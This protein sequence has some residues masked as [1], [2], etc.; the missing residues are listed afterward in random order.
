MEG[1]PARSV[2]RPTSRMHLIVG[3]GNPG[4]RYRH[5][6]HN[7]GFLTVDRLASDEKIRLTRKVAGSLVGLGEIAGTDVVLAKPLSYMNL[8]GEPVGSLLDCCKV[9][10]DRLLVVYDDLALPWTA[11]RIR[12]KGS[13]GGHRGVK[14]I[15]ETI[16]T[17]EFLRLRLGIRPQEPVDDGAAYVLAP[18]G[19]S[20]R[21][22]LDELLE[23]AASAVRL[24]ISDGAA[25]AM[26]ACNRRAVGSEATEI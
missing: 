21:K 19:P 11:L 3:L 9:K 14:S 13:A 8:S 26:T 20:R 2:D 7:L 15:I 18:F 12:E 6:P 17:D 4:P 22:Q 5:T 24:I 16:G 1:Q 10:H 23:R 25:K